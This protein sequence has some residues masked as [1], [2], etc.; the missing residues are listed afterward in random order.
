M[1]KLLVNAENWLKLS[2]KS[3]F[4]LIFKNTVEPIFQSVG[5]I[6]R[7]TPTALY[8]EHWFHITFFC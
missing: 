2:R 3:I 6:L 4:L 1:P 7:H 8:R 5:P